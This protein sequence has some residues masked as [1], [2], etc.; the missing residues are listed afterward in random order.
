ML[1]CNHRLILT[2]DSISFVSHAYSRQSFAYNTMIMTFPRK[3]KRH[4]S[5]FDCL[6]PSIAYIAL[7]LRKQLCDACTSPC[8]FLFSFNAHSSFLCSKPA[9]NQR[10]MSSFSFACSKA[11]ANS[12]CLP[13]RLYIAS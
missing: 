2:N 5:D 10:Y 9:G 11:C 6:N 1:I 3:R 7:N 8:M 4:R 12:I 13:F